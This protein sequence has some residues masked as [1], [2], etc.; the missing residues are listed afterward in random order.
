MKKIKLHNTVREETLCEFV[1]FVS[2]FK[3]SHDGSGAEANYAKF[4]GADRSTINRYLKGALN[5][6]II[7]LRLMQAMNDRTQLKDDNRRLKKGI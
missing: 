4:T 3:T 5:I 7:H 6:P 2:T 1:D